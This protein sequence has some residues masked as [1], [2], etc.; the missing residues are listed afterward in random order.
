V[1]ATPRIDASSIHLA[2]ELGF[3]REAGFEVEIL[4]NRNTLHAMALLAGGG[5]DIHF[6]TASTAFLNAIIKGLPLRITAGRDIA[7]GTCEYIGA[8]YGL[9]R[10]FPD[11][12]ADIAKLKGKRVATGPAIGIGQFSLDAQLARAGL[13]EKDVTVVHLEY[14]QILAALLGGGVDACIG[15]NDFDRNLTSLGAEIVHTGGLAQVYPNFQYTYVL[16]GK[17]M[18]AADVDRGARFLSAYL[19]GAREF[20]RGKTPRFLEELVRTDRLDGKKAVTS[21]RDSFVLD[22]SID[23]NSLRLYA[24]WAARNKYISRPVDVSELVD[25]RFLRRA[26]AR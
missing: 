15:A 20:A 13:S 21:C 24:D 14:G 7:N 19:R 10:T 12:L 23:L 17:T 5:L 16:F 18:L 11:G 26:H 8:V 3:F 6:G 25:D 1:G 22:G 4:Q 9:R 2:F